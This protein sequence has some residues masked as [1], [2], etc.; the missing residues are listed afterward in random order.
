MTTKNANTAKQRPTC[1]L[2][3]ESYQ[4]LAII[5]TWLKLIDW[6]Q[7]LATSYRNWQIQKVTRFHTGLGY[8]YHLDAM[9]SLSL[10]Y[11]MR[12]ESASTSLTCPA[13][14]NC[15]KEATENA[16]YQAL[17]AGVLVNF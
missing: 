7:T 12:Q 9:K 1:N 4:Q 17:Q 16:N 6:W 10:A 13:V 5:G 15:K 2:F 11:A 3:Q 8:H 14:A